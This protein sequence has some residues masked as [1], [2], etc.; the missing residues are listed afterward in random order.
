MTTARRLSAA[1]AAGVLALLAVPS[2]ARSADP[3]PAVE[4]TR[5]TNDEST[6]EEQGLLTATVTPGG[7]QHSVEEVEFELVP[8]TPSSDPEDPCFVDLGDQAVQPF[9]GGSASQD[10]ALDVD[11][12]CNRI[13]DITAKVP[14]ETQG[15]VGLAG[16]V[17]STSD[18]VEDTVRFSTA[19]PPAEVEGLEATYDPGTREVRL[20]W[21]PNPEPDLI[22]YRVE[23]NPP[24]RDGFSRIGDE[25]VT[26]TSF[27]D[28][29]IGE[30]HRYR[31]IAVREG[32]APGSKIESEPS[33][34]VAS[35]P[36]VP[37]PTGPDV[38][39]PNQ[40]RSD[41]ANR[42]S[43]AGNRSNRA[44][45]SPDRGSRAPSQTRTTSNIFEET[46]PF[47]PSQ[48]TTTSPEPPEDAAVLAEFD[49]DLSDAEQ[50]RATLVPVAGGLALLVGAMHL[51]L[52][53]RRA[54]ESDIP[55]VPR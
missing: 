37:E 42:S 9:N 20:T 17:G 47:D 16:N 8:Q 25:V 18:V 51:F 31:V 24:G 34:S 23:R 29:D 48:T 40:S 4:W 41:P 3:D 49:D 10:F 15:P 28:P 39:P 32:A 50:R 44:G 2:A 5:P 55:I 30:E 1:A 7:D 52:L 26:E 46:L 13:Y 36:D 33:R 43:G 21:A 6:L 22:G 14:F 45:G 53:S 35:G 27:T 11:F 19:I 54:G 38:P 12:P